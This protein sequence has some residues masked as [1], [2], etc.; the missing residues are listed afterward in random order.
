VTG[1]VSTLGG[2]VFGAGIDSLYNGTIAPFAIS[3]AVMVTIAYGFYRWAD[4][5]W[6]KA[7][8]EHQSV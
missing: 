7:A 8:A 1:T 5:T 2:A 4:T 6:D 3:G